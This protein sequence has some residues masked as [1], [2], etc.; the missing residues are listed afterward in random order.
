[1]PSLKSLINAKFYAIKQYEV[2]YTLYILKTKFWVE[3]LH[4]GKK[5]ENLNF[6]DSVL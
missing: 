6:L 5:N 2:V 1:M 4:P 3:N